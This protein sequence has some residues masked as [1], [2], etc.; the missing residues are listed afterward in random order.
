MG[1]PAENVPGYQTVRITLPA[2][3]VA[4]LADGEAWQ[5]RAAYPNAAFVSTVFGVAQEREEGGWLLHPYFGALAPQDARDTMGGHFR[6][7]AQNASQDGD[8]AAH[9]E[10]LRAGVRMDWEP[11]DE[12]TVL[13]TRY[14]VVRADQFV[15][16]GPAGPEPPRPTD[17]DPG[18]PDKARAV[19]DPAAGFVIDPVTPVSFAAGMLR[20]DLLGLM[21]GEGMVPRE[22]HNDAVNA[23]QTHPGGVLLPAAFM[24]AEQGEGRW[25]ATLPD[26]SPTPQGARDALASYLR[27]I[28][29]WQMS[30]NA[31]QRAA[32]AAAADRLSDERADEL[33]VAGR[34]FRIVRVERLVRIGPDGPEGPR[35]SDPDPQPPVMVQDQQ[36]RAQGLISDEEDENKPPELSDDAKALL[37]ILN[38]EQERRSE[39]IAKRAA[40]RPPS[41]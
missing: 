18:E 33:S 9:D 2:T 4:E 22:V 39:R 12:A 38:E 17:A 5:A 15:R 24:V 14:R 29:P 40:R 37:Q 35:P 30:L 36:M 3:P 16:S 13:G 27:V 20:V 10:C 23:A 34:T 32:Y 28:V 8:Q 1:G 25:G 6:K 19:P 26:T 21:P 31:K 11:I 7:L 41:S